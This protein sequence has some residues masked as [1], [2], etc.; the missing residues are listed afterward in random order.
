MSWFVFGF[1]QINEITSFDEFK[2][3]VHSEVESGEKTSL[4]KVK[5]KNKRTLFVCP[6]CQETITVK[7]DPKI[8]IESTNFPISILFLHNPKSNPHL[9]LIYMDKQGKI[10]AVERINYNTIPFNYGEICKENTECLLSL[11]KMD[12][13]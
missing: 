12:L 3:Q 13:K 7:F 10:R 6:I 8:L 11:E 4:S 1:N 9:L 5:S 2:E